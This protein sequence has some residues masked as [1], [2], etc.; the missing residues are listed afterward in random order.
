MSRNSKAIVLCLWDHDFSPRV[1]LTAVVSL[2]LAFHAVHLTASFPTSLP[3]SLSDLKVER[4]VWECVCKIL[5]LFFPSFVCIEFYIYVH[6]KDIVSYS[7]NL[8]VPKNTIHNYPH[9]YIYLVVPWVSLR[10]SISWL[11]SS[12]VM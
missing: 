6:L 5:S 11:G 1:V 12:L 10:C 3:W 4:P 7:A 8:K 9:Q 2:G